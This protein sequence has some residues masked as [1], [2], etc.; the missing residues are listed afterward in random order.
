MLTRILASSH[1]IRYDLADCSHLRGLFMSDIKRCTMSL[2]ADLVSQLDK[3]ST[4][5]G[6]SRSALVAELLAEPVGVLDRMISVDNL[7]EPDGLRRL[8]GD[9]MAYVQDKVSELRRLLDDD[10]FGG[11]DDGNL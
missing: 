4:L 6:I 1:L 5:A 3:L 8:R 10:L 2:P 11:V 7:P 9:S